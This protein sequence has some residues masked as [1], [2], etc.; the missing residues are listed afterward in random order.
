L[1]FQTVAKDMPVEEMQIVSF[2]PGLIW[3]EQWV[4][5]GFTE[6]TGFDDSQYSPTMN[7]FRCES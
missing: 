2:H 1:Y 3:Q 7:F 4:K 6:P 5:M